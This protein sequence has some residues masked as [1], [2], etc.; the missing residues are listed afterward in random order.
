MSDCLIS[1]DWSCQPCVFLVDFSS[2]VSGWVTT[3]QVGG[4][5]RVGHRIEA[6]DSA[7]KWLEAEVIDEDLDSVKIHYK[8]W[9]KKYDEWIPRNSPRI[10]QYG[11]FK[12]VFKAP[13]P[14]RQLSLTRTAS[15]E[16][17][18]II[19]NEAT[20][21]QYEH[22]KRALREHGLHVRP[23]QGDGNCMFRSV[24]HQVY[25]DDSHHMLVRQMCMDYMVPFRVSS[26]FVLVFRVKF[27][28]QWVR[29]CVVPHM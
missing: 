15:Q 19:R 16:R 21:Q 5:L 25:G 8:N 7:K 9:H 2:H 6:L 28:S 11:R 12:K 22:Y 26:P 1:T 13:P 14:S 23:V 29:T 17:T 27:M 3:V 24:A 10:R 18:R 20:C 4:V